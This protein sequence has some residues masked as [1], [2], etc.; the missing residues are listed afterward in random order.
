LDATNT[1]D[2]AELLAGLSEA[3]ATAG[4]DLLGVTSAEPIALREEWGVDQ[5]REL[6]PAARSVVVAGFSTRYEPR[7]A[8]SEP[9]IPRGRFPVYGSRVFEQMERHCWDVVGGFLRERGYAAVAAPHL[10]IKPAVVRAGL[11][12]YGKHAVVVTRE[13]GSMIMFAA[14]IT[15]APLATAAED[16]PVY[17]ETCPK[18]C[19][20]CV[21]ACPT[22]ALS[23]DYRLDRAR[24]VTNWL[25]GEFMP[26]ELRPQAQDRL[27]G[28]GECLFACPRNARVP[29]KTNYPVQTDTVGDSPELIPLAAGDRDYYD[30]VVPTFP[31]RA[32]FETMRGSAIVA[33]GN[34]GDPAAVET[35]GAILAEP[36]PRLRAY[37][38][39]ALGRIATDRSRAL[40]Q[41]AGDREADPEVSAEIEAA[42]C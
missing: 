30:R 24:C 18:G 12:R 39:W 38:A 4:I 29:V 34:A 42:L 35:L 1:A 31:R 40:L 37:S 13:F 19:R 32:G 7:L 14:T 33:L 25:W 16:A 36:D 17:A 6:L 2:S 5:P 23:G 41:A 8:P 20:R 9:G 11:G 26:P 22:G 3:T 15:D 10:P 27:F 28:C 21:D